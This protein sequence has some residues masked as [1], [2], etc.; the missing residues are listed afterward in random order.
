MT[1]HAI[2]STEALEALYDAPGR[3]SLV[4]ETS[5]LTAPYRALIEAS[6][7]VVIATCG[8][9]GLDCSPRGDAPGFVLVEDEC[10]LALPDRRGNNRIDSLRNLVRDPRIALLF[11]VPGIDE[12]LRVE[13]RAV[14]STDPARLAVHAVAG[15]TPRNV[16]V[17]TIRS[18]FFQCSRALVRAGLW[19]P[20]RRVARG[21]LPSAG[22]MLKACT[23]DFDAE[24]YDATQP[25]RVKST[26][27]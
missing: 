20:E 25:E 10:T 26:L 1:H 14:I 5:G 24:G 19:A 9:E 22:Q 11:F 17:V 6:P 15:K 21:D 7:F 12:T 3:A 27:Y 18:V 16:L 8:P 13:G 23:D 2:T 4:K